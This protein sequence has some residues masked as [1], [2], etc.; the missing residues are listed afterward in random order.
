MNDIAEEKT[1]P[2]KVGRPRKNPS[3][4]VAGHEDEIRELVEKKKNRG[5]PPVQVRNDDIKSSDVQKS[6]A[7]VMRWYGRE[8]VRSDDEVEERLRE[9]FTV[10]IEAGELPSVEKMALCLGTT[11]WSLIDWEKGVGC[12]A[13]RQALIKQAKE[14]LAAMD[15]DL[16]SNNKIPQVTYIFRAKNFFGMKDQTDVVVTPNN[17]VGAEVPEDELRKRIAGDVVTDRAIDAEFTE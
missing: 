3:P 8:L 13:R 7:S 11:R 4:L 9:F 10:L 6:L 1:A 5:A 15:A 12:S 2:K 17:I 16:V 14:M